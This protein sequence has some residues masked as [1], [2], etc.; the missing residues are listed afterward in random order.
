MPAT[1]WDQDQDRA[2]GGDEPVREAPG[3][4]YGPRPAPDVRAR[5]SLPFNQ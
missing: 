3:H 5:L 2:T 1:E 4:E